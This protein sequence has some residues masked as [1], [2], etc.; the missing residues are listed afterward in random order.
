MLDEYTTRL[1]ETKVTESQIESSVA[2]EE[3]LMRVEIG[4]ESTES[5]HMSGRAEE[6]LNCEETDPAAGMPEQT[7]G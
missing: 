5:S 3:R 7:F 6:R 1:N 2:E 4:G